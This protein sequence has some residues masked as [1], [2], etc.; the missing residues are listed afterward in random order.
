[1]CDGNPDL[2]NMKSPNEQAPS[3]ESKIR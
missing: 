3:M 1:V 2:W